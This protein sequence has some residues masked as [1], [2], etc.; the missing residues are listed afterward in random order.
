[1]RFL[2]ACICCSLSLARLWGQ[3]PQPSLEARPAGA[4]TRIE[5]RCTAPEAATLT[6][7]MEAHKTGPSGQ[8]HQTQSGPVPA[9]GGTLATLALNLGPAD[10]CTVVLRLRDESGLLAETHWRFPEP[11]TGGEKAVEDP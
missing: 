11:D 4:L 9:Q 10:T 5:A 8:S 3:A 1:M 7:V 6:Y 2:L